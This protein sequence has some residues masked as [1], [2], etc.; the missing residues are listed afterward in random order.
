M[1]AVSRPARPVLMSVSAAVVLLG[2]FLP[3]VRFGARSRSSYRLL[4][5]V[6]RLQFT[7][8]S[9]QAAAVRAWPLV[10]LLLVAAVYA[11][12]LHRPRLGGSI[13]VV[14][15]VYAGGLAVAVHRAPARTLRGVDIVILGGLALLVTS[16]V[17]LLPARH[18]P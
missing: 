10:P 14:A 2:T 5:L 12:W 7:R 18:P 1:E 11:T 15:A 3:W 16:L 13:G 8:G 17:Q 6:D 4:G 9:L